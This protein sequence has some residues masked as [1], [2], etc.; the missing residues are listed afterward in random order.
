MIGVLV[1][2]VVEIVA[3][4]LLGVPIAVYLITTTGALDLPRAEQKMVYLAALHA[5]HIAAGL[6]LGTWAFSSILGGYVAGRIAKERTIVVGAL[7]S[8]ACLALAADA[9]V[10]GI[11][12]QPIG[13]FL[14]WFPGGPLFGALGGYL[15]QRTVR[16]AS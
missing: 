6:S 8:Y 3:A 12:G 13:Q 15:T 11:S 7:S 14:L 9:L 10:H 1:G 5:N 16:A 4:N 2:G